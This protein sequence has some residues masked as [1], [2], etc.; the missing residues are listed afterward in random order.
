MLTAASPFFACVLLRDKRC[1]WPFEKTFVL[2][3][4]C[5]FGPLQ[6]RFP[7]S[8]HHVVE[9]YAVLVLSSGLLSWKWTFSSARFQLWSRRECGM[10]VYLS[11]GEK[12]ALLGKLGSLSVNGEIE[13]QRKELHTPW[14]CWFVRILFPRL[15]LRRLLA[16]FSMSHERLGLF[17][18]I[19]K[20]VSF[21]W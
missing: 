14:T 6:L 17:F 11:T 5:R 21:F 13:M 16:N 2:Q 9:L 10:E 7:P 8:P 18:R 4:S 15:S 19:S 3:K 20:S 12:A 1:C